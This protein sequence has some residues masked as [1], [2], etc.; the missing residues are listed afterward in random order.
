[1]LLGILDPAD[2][3]VYGPGRDVLPGIE[4]RG[5][6]ASVSCEGLLEAC[7]H[8]TGTRGLLTGHDNELGFPQVNDAAARPDLVRTHGFGWWRTRTRLGAPDRRGSV[9]CVVYLIVHVWHDESPP[10]LHD[11]IDLTTVNLEPED[12]SET[13]RLA[14]KRHRN[15]QTD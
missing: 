6:G 10:Q 5:V 9:D 12:R 2:E 14:A 15:E 13:E 7:A 1:L 3:L 11:S 4:C 8:A